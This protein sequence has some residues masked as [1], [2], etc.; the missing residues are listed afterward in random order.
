[1][2]LISLA[3]LKAENVAPG[4]DERNKKIL[5]N[6]ISSSVPFTSTGFQSK[7]IHES[8]GQYFNDRCDDLEKWP[9][10]FLWNYHNPLH[11]SREDPLASHLHLNF[12]RSSHRGIL[13]LNPKK[14]FLYKTIRVRRD[15]IRKVLVLSSSFIRPISSSHLILIVDLFRVWLCALLLPVL[16]VKHPRSSQRT[17]CNPFHRIIHPIHPFSSITMPETYPGSRIN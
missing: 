12:L 5:D 14:L 4:P 9:L 8:L 17:F 15:I 2:T 13:L 11:I 7:P 10:R 1:M 6:F 3:Q 16:S